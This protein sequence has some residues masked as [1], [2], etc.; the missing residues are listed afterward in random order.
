MSNLKENEDKTNNI[1][2]Q[3]KNTYSPDM[4][5]RERVLGAWVSHNPLGDLLTKCALVGQTRE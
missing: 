3:V 2:I 5:R 4:G 1:K